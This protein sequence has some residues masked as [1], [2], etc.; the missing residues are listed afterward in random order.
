[1]KSAPDAKLSYQQNAVS[2][3]TPLQ[4]VVILYDAAIEDMRRALTTMENNDIEARGQAVRHALL[5]LEQLQGTFDSNMARK[6]Q[7]ILNSSIT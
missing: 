4:L 2:G 5:V 6:P 1:M 7:N 3:A